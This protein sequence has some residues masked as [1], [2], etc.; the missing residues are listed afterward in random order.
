M[1]EI[2]RKRTR[3]VDKKPCFGATRAFR[4]MPSAETKSVT[5]VGAGQAGLQVALSLRLRGFAGRI[6]LLG[7][8]NHLPYQRPPLS[9]AFLKGE[10]EERRLYLK[11]VTFYPDQ[12]IDLHL[13]AS[14]ARID[15]SERVV[16]TGD[17]RT[18]GY[19]RLVLATGATP[20]RIPLAGSNRDG[21]CVLR[22]I[23]DAL[24]L[25]QCLLRDG[26]LIVVGGGYIG[27]E[28]ASAAR[29]LGCDVS[30]IERL[31][32]VMSRVTSPVVSNFYLELHR[33]HGVDIRLGETITG[34]LGDDRVTGVRLGS[35]EELAATTVLVGVGVQPNQQIA[36]EAGLHCDNGILVD[37]GLRTSDPSIFAAG[38]CAC[39]VLPDGHTLRLES[40]HSARDHGERIAANLAGD[41]V[42][43]DDPPWFWSDQYDVKLQTAGLSTD[44]AELQ[45]R[46]DPGTGHFSV[47]YFLNRELTAVDAVN[48]PGTFMAVKQLLKKQVRVTADAV[49]DPK[50]DLKSLLPATTQRKAAL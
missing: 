39:R 16:V 28:V 18:F 3:H 13:S 25:R 10:L 37:G 45:V 4:S 2:V 1:A 33:R 17:G 24:A 41:A 36:A 35:G 8:E 42:V 20:L 44:F 40:V 38:D 34:I 43:R 7:D 19:D 29:Q 31:P 47:L 32:R 5:I 9:K 50:L 49:R 26:R 48:D 11:P 12:G 21:V 23:D 14:V 30:V 27:L 22:D 46:G 6:T 15:R